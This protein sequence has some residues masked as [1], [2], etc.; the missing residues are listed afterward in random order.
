VRVK[1]ENDEGE[2]L[3]LLVVEEQTD[4]DKKH[5]IVCWRYFAPGQSERDGNVWEQRSSL[6]ST[7]RALWEAVRRG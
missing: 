3:A 1:V 4:E 2:L 7:A 5:G 6:Q